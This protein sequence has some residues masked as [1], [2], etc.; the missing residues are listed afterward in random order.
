MAQ[1]S[2]TPLNIIESTAR[3]DGLSKAAIMML[4]LPDETVRKIFQQLESSEVMDLSQQMATLGI[5]KSQVVEDLYSEFVSK[6]GVNGSVLGNY[7]STE[8]MLNKFFDKDRVKEMM[9]EIRGPAGRNMWEKLANVNEAVL[10]NYLRNE[11]PQTAAVILSKIKAE[12]AAKVFPLLPQPLAMDIIMRILKMEVVQRDILEDIERTLKTE[13]MSNLAKSH[14]RD[15]Y[16]HIA[17]VFNSFDR[18]TES[19]FMSALEVNYSDAAERIKSLMFTFDDI[20]R[21]DNSGVQTV[22]RVADKMRLALALKGSSEDIKALFFNNMSERAAKL[23]K[24]D[25]ASM[26]MVRLR[27]V[28]DAQLEIVNLT[29]ELANKGEI[30]IADGPEEEQLIA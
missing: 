3:L 13:F 8:R 15:P 9:E 17:E 28:D 1:Q 23:M 16:E 27:D 22:I 14:Q 7:E 4:S 20:I 19:V 12:H 10:A 24:D 25:M 26:G 2:D 18:A 29:K 30:L 11:Y 5:V 21:L 6:V